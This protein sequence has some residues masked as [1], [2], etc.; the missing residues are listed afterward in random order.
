MIN[1][2]ATLKGTF[3]SDHGSW[4]REDANAGV[5]HGV[6]G[7]EAW[8]NGA[9]WI[10]DHGRLRGAMGV[11]DHADFIARAA[12]GEFVNAGLCVRG[13]EQQT[14]RKAECKE[15][16]CF[17][18]VR[19]VDVFWGGSPLE[20]FHGVILDSDDRLRPP[21]FGEGFTFFADLAESD[22]A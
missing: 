2:D 3:P 5:I 16:D 22:R 6:E 8:I 21:Y 7:C 20:P 13:W 4:T 11:G 1:V 9:K 12:K 17:E 18:R 19:R 10:R 14:G 15:G